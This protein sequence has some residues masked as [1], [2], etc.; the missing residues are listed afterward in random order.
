MTLRMITLA[1]VAA[2]A[3]GAANAQ[4][5]AP[6][7]QAPPSDAASPVPPSGALAQASPAPSDTQAPPAVLPASS[8]TLGDPAA[9]KAGDTG[10]VSNG[11]V[12]DTPD[13]RAK[14]GKPDSSTGKRT[15]P[16]GN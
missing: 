12:P 11:P 14:Y 3:A 16:T 5:Q 10:V 15:Q 13:N 6:A 8:S 1:P 7:G 2:L 9:L 4:T